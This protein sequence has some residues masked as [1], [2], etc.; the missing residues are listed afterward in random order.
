MANKRRTNPTTM[1][2]SKPERPQTALAAVEAQ[3]EVE[4]EELRQR[5]VSLEAEAV[6]VGGGVGPGSSGWVLKVNDIRRVPVEYMRAGHLLRDRVSAE[7]DRLVQSGDS[8]SIP[9]LL[10][11][12]TG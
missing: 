5:I 7:L 4:V 1:P 11:S 12:R 2:D 3:F 6:G 8:P 10:I 9:G